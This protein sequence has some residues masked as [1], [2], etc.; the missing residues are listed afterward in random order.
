MRS[1]AVTP[2]NV[3]TPDPVVEKQ[4]V[5]QLLRQG[6]LNAAF[7]QVGEVYIKSPVSLEAP[8]FEH[9]F[10]HAVSVRPEQ[11]ILPPTPT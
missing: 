11:D 7:Q 9:Y 4:H 3:G 6:Q 5:L 8:M 1:G 2:A 10:H